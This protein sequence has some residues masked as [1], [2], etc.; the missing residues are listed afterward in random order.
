MRDGTA[1][2][3]WV[4]GWVLRGG[5]EHD[6]PGSGQKDVRG[7][8]IYI[9][10]RSSAANAEGAR[11]IHFNR[12]ASSGI[13]KNGANYEKEARARAGRAGAALI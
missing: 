8:G 4:A 12:F 3:G 9:Y 7:M 13:G 5:D 10:V 11:G 1:G 2:M 6:F